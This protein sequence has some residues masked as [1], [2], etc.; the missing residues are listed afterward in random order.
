[1]HNKPTFVSIGR[2]VCLCVCVPER[3]RCRF[4]SLHEVVGGALA[5]C[6][7]TLMATCWDLRRYKE[8]GKNS[9]AFCVQPL[10]IF[11]LFWPPLLLFLEIA[12][13]L[14]CFSV[15]SLCGTLLSQGQLKTFQQLL[16]PVA[17]G[18]LCV[19][20]L[21]LWDTHIS[22][23]TPFGSRQTSWESARVPQG[24]W[25]CSSCMIT[26]LVPSDPAD[27]S[28]EPGGG[29]PRPHTTPAVTLPFPAF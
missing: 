2:C 1:M 20:A 24:V 10:F 19:V 13:F 14:N 11:Y 9:V 27:G 15:V 7:C 23:S 18:F 4:M 22:A 5:V 3:V 21:W 16:G 26:G 8:Q 29:A 17:G 6:V 12:I 28:I 25:C